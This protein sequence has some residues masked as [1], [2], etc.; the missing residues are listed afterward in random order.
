[1]PSK[2][3]FWVRQRHCSRDV[4]RDVVAGHRCP[5]SGFLSDFDVRTRVVH[6]SGRPAR[7]VGLGQDKRTR[8]RLWFEHRSWNETWDAM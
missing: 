1:M 5:P 7:R 3:E 2:T 6:G 8:G 4:Q